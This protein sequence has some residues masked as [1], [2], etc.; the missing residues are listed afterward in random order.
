MDTAHTTHATDEQ[1]FDLELTGMTCASCVGRVERALKAVP[2]V[3]GASVNL[4]TEKATVRLVRG[5]P[6]AP[7]LG[8]ISDAGYTARLPEAT[9][10]SGMA[11]RRTHR[12][13]ETVHLVLAALF[14]LPLVVPMLALPFGEHWMLPGWVQWLLATPVQFWLGARF[15][16]AGWKAL[17]A[18]TGNMDLLVAIGTSAAYGLSV[19]H[20][21]APSSHHGTDALYFEASAVIVTLILLGKWLESRAKRQT[22]AAIRALQAI[23]PAFA[24]VIRDGREEEVAIDAVNAGDRIV[25]LPG[26]RIPVDGTILSGRTHA[27]ESLITGESVPVAKDEGDRLIGGA[28]NGEGRVVVQT[29]AVGGETALARIIRLV[30]DAQAKKAPIQRIVDR[31]SA[32]FV[33]VVVAIALL[34]VLGWGTA[35]GDWTTAVLN[36]VAVLV[37]ACPCA[38]GLA[39]PTA[40]MAGTGAAARAG[41]L[42]KDAEA[43]E[44]ARTIRTVAF[45]KTGTLTEGRPTLAEHIAVHGD[46]MQLLALTAAVQRGSEH[47]LARAVVLAAE[48]AGLRLQNVENVQTRAARSGRRAH[49]AGWKHAV[50]A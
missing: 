4:A 29:T 36:A 12:S 47:P 17:R 22:T 42:I 39:T 49:A 7:L 45:D 3:L 27:D 44:A 23:R 13:P 50:D 10:P 1:S 15:Y 31:V 24:R 21:L 38:L 16:R 9:A 14:T 25:V 2:G 43:L 35:T 34:T 30:E 11:A 41:I 5:T 26:E 48:A 8:A 19:Y 37:I 6:I 32:V 46:G 20:L 28:I 33:P 18:R 40:I